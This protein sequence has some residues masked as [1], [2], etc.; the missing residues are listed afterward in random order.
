MQRGG[1]TALSVLTE[2]K[3][4]NGSLEALAQARADV[5]LPIL[6]KDIVLSPDSNSSSLKN[7]SQ[8][9]FADSSHF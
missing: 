6:M 2:P 5:K 1:A 3:Q 9:R 8:C 4:F 7:G